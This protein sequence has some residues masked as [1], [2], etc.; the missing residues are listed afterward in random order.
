MR[1]LLYKFGTQVGAIQRAK[2]ILRVSQFSRPR[3][4]PIPR[5]CFLPRIRCLHSRV[6]CHKPKQLRVPRQM[7]VRFLSPEPHHRSRSFTFYRSGEQER[8]G[9]S[10]F[11]FYSQSNSMVRGERQHVLLRNKCQGGNKCRSSIQRC[12]QEGNGEG[13]I[14]KVCIALLF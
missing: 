8:F 14:R 12:S 13:E 10:A 7:E 1:W 5:P 2:S 4:I 3:T 11:D 9:R 6:R